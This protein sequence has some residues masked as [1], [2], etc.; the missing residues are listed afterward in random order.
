MNES[1]KPDESPDESLADLP[2][3]PV[4]DSSVPLAAHIG[5]GAIAWSVA[6]AGAIVLIAGSL[7]PTM[8]ATRST[9][10]EWEQ[11]KLEIEQAVQDSQV[12]SQ[13][14]AQADEQSDGQSNID[15]KN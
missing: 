5:L 6:G 2:P 13:M 3:K 11:R 12:D 7:T 14:D 10:L 8:G 4:D 9:K 15:E 1:E